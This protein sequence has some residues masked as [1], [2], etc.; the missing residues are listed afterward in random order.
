MSMPFVSVTMLQALFGQA[1]AGGPVEEPR[2]KAA[3]EFRRVGYGLGADG[4][5]I[6]DDRGSRNGPDDKQAA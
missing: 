6:R 5:S 4:A 2:P 3:A 1:M